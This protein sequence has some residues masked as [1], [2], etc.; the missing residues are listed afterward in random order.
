MAHSNCSPH[1][2]RSTSGSFAATAFGVLGFVLAF[3]LRLTAQ[4]VLTYHNDAARTGQNPNETRLSPQ[5]VNPATFGK[6][7]S[8]GTDGYVYAQ[9][10][11]KSSVRI[12]GGASHNVVLVATEHNSVYA[13][14][15]DSNTGPNA[16]P[17]WN[18]N[19]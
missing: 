7:F 9:P 8:Y 4:D 17:L 2:W 14:D 18:V 10:L 15:A 12:A 11:Y 16:N 13:F 1:A 19:L 5:N 3:S 6:L